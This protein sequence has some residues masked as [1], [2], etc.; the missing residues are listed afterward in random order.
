MKINDSPESEEERKYQE[1]RQ[2]HLR[3]SQQFYTELR[4][5][6]DM[7]KENNNI[8]C[9]SFDFEQNLPLP[10]IYF[11]PMSTLVICFWST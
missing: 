6:T 3:E 11:L 4:T 2:K 10:H 8:L 1:H 5:S 7:A 9:V